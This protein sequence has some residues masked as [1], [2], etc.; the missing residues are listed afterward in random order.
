M[1]GGFQA[2][3]FRGWIPLDDRALPRGAAGNTAINYSQPRSVDLSVLV[4]LLGYRFEFIPG[5]ILV[6]G[7]E[8]DQSY[9]EI[10]H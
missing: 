10:Q 1:K 7:A 8:V 6:S 3:S 9:N 2:L 4:G 5:G